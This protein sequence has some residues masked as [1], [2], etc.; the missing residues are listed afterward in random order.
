MIAVAAKTARA[1]FLV[2]LER[3]AWVVSVE[4]VVCERSLERSI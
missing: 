4:A 2:L 3:E 1:P